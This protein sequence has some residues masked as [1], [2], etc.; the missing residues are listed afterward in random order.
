MNWKTL[1][2]ASAGIL[3]LAVAGCTSPLGALIRGQSPDGNCETGQGAC[4]SGAIVYG[5]GCQEIESGRGCWLHRRHGNGWY[6]TDPMH[7]EYESQHHTHHWDYIPPYGLTYPPDGQPNAAVFYPYY[8]LKGPD[9]FF[10]G[11]KSR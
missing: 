4:R 1:L 6:Q 7:N 11:M 10:Y 5:N 3:L 2:P 9:D 8:T